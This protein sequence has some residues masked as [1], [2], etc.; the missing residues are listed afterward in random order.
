MLTPLHC[1]YGAEKSAAELVFTYGFLPA[2][3][4]ATLWLALDLRCPPDDPLARAKE[5]VAHSAPMLRVIDLGGEIL[6]TGS[7]VWLMCVNEED[8]LSFR[9]LQRTDGTRSLQVLWCGEEVE[10]I[11]GLEAMLEGSG[12]WEVYQLRALMLVQERVSVQL[13]ELVAVEEEL[14]RVE[15]TEEGEEGGGAREVAGRLRQLERRLMEKVVECLED[16]KEKLLGTAVVREYLRTAGMDDN[17]GDGGDDEE[18]DGI[19]V[20]AKGDGVEDDGEDLS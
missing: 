14:A 8:G 3:Q 2:S 10:D 20:K 1:S 4:R 11:A 18:E 19:E 7:F 15:E 16:Q 5:A 9:V 12:L 17:S 6:W 13:G